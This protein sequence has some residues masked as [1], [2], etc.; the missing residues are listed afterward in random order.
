MGLFIEF[1]PKST[2]E[3]WDHRMDLDS[4]RAR[5]GSLSSKFWTREAHVQGTISAFHYLILHHEN[6]LENCEFP[7]EFACKMPI[8]R[9]FWYVWFSWESGGW[10]SCGSWPKFSLNGKLSKELDE[11][12]ENIIMIYLS[13]YITQSH[14]ILAWKVCCI[15]FFI[16]SIHFVFF[17]SSTKEQKR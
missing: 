3:T 2:M 17:P 11:L 10:I 8:E 5:E 14:H 16:L 15:H 6:R 9:M 4:C 13:Q 7:D 1:M 12:M